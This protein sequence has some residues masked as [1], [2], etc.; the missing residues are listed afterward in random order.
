MRFLV[1][2]PQP[3][4]GR[5]ADKLRARGA[6]AVESPM[7]K[8][9]AT[10]PKVL[11]LDKVTGLAFTSSRAVT[12]LETHAQIGDLRKLPGFAV[13]GRTADMLKQAGFEDVH[14]AEGDV[15]ALS[16]MIERHQP[17]GLLLY[18][19]A[20]NHAGNLKKSLAEKQVRCRPI[21]IYQM[22]KC[23]HFEPAILSDLEAAAFDG[24][25][26][27]SKRTAEAFVTAMR[28]AGLKG[29]PG[30]THVYAI[31]PRA[32]EPFSGHI[33]VQTAQRPNEDALLG[34]ALRVS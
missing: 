30:E 18:P 15:V 6:D 11:D 26:I 34:L 13:G 21:E 8:L 10:V 5:S 23:L 32:A 7:L 1:T 27:Y 9:N 29:L 19:C 33:F 2:R 25:L 12:L 16:R 17:H 3:E 24:V 22:E 20:R 31:S 14:S 4:C 28:V